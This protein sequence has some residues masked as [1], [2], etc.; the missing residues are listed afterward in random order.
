MQHF[1]TV[2]CFVDKKQRFND[3]GDP[4]LLIKSVAQNEYHLCDAA[5][6]LFVRFR[7]AGKTFPPYIVYKIFANNICDVGA[8]APRNYSQGT[9]I[10]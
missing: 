4:V 10:F 2:V 6:Q 7:L 3:S 9:R 8:Y 5:S 1:T